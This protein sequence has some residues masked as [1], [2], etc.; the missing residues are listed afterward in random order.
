[1]AYGLITEKITTPE[2]ID[3]IA[4]RSSLNKEEIDHIFNLRTDL[5]FPST[6]TSGF[7]QG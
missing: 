7:F 6:R 3:A 4:K 2:A 5:M 1:M